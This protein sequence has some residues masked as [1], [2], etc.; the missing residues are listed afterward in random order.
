MRWGRRLI[1]HSRPRFWFYL[2]GPVL[3]GTAF[4]AP[5]VAA[6]FS[7]AAVA[8][9]LYFL[10]PA[11]TFLYGIND[12]FDASVDRENP[13]KDGPEV[14]SRRSQTEAT[15]VLVAGLLG[16]GLAAILPGIALPYL[17]GFLFL[18]A[19][20]SA[21]P[22]RLKTKPP[23]DS[24]SNGLYVLPGAAAYTVLAGTHPPLL[25]LLGGWL[26]TM[27]MHTY[28]AVPDITPDERAGIRTTATVLGR[29]NALLYCAVIWLLAAAVFGVLSLRAGVILLV[30]PL[31]VGW[32]LLRNL[33]VARLY[34]LYPGINTAVGMVFTLA[35][36][37]RVIYG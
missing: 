25:A 20:Y 37:W 4:G 35:G 33:D 17:A 11:N 26:W 18:G 19:A 6:L 8:L 12:F 15:A 7:P 24:I 21:P 3:V 1:R 5:S 27:A 34:W 16:I 36:L 13:K 28:S 9:F 30:Y 22:L 10:V 32:M 23:L 29:R 2:A 31:L 14:Q